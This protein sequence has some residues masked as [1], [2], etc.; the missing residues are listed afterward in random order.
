MLLCAPFYASAGEQQLVL[1]HANAQLIIERFFNQTLDFSQL[2]AQKNIYLTYWGNTPTAEIKHE[3]QHLTIG[4]QG[5]E[6]EQLHLQLGE[7]VKTISF[8]LQG[9]PAH[10]SNNYI[11]SHQGKVSV[12]TPAVYELSN[13]VLALSDKYRQSYQQNHQG[14][15]YYQ[16]MLQ[17]FSPFATH[18]LISKLK[19]A[20]YYSLVEN[21]PAY[22][23]KKEQIKPSEVYSG[24]RAQNAIKDYNKLLADFAKE[25]KFHAFYQQHQNYYAS[26]HQ[27]FELSVQPQRIWQWL[28]H[29]FPG[30]YNS[31]RV[32]FSPLGIGN[33]SARM[34]DNNG[35]KESVMFIS[36]PNRYQNEEISASLKA[37]KLTRSFF[38][39]IDHTYVNPISDLYIDEINQAL[40]DL[41]PWYKGGGY[42]KP[43]LVF[44]E[45]MTWA[46]F[47]LYA[48]EHYP[49]QDFLQIKDDIENFMSQKRG[50]YLFKAFNE[51]LLKMYEKKK[52][53]EKIPDLYPV[54][55]DWFNH[56]T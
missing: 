22:Q 9:Q 29:Q 44:N 15:D 16:Q 45:Y 7:E 18:P 32:F 40:A 41:T 27:Q 37:I 25:S 28:E 34:Y 1:Q 2:P 35:F 43:Y 21:G 10:Y 53:T 50:F 51:Q 56:K 6:I 30:R 12:A 46:I 47:S 5:D 48:K 42:N 49:E 24:F 36:G 20:D 52:P 4:Y 3:D 26:L 31:Y 19:E 23:F 38:T 17:W 55:I 39:E 8:Y 14:E 54:L 33:H 11:A 13:I